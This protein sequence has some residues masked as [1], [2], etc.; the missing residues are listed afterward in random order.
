MRVRE[1]ERARESDGDTAVVRR[2]SFI[3]C[4]RGDKYEIKNDVFDQ[5]EQM[6]EVKNKNFPFFPHINNKNKLLMYRLPF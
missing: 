2:R 4:I 5:Q 6:L 3:I 1:R